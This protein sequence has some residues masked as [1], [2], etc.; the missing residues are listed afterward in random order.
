MVEKMLAYFGVCQPKV[1]VEVPS[2]Q[3]DAS[4]DDDTYSD[5]EPIDSHID[6]TRATERSDKPRPEQQHREPR[7]TRP[8]KHKCTHC[9]I[10]DTEHSDCQQ[11]DNVFCNECQTIEG[12]PVQSSCHFCGVNLCIGCDE[13]YQ[14]AVLSSSWK[15]RERV[16][17]FC[18][19]RC[20]K[21]S[22]RKCQRSF[23][24]INK[25]VYRNGQMSKLQL[26]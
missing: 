12:V 3:E 23:N 14:A 5:D 26:Q 9:G 1:T 22:L 18:S 15:G 2:D 7:W 4:F 21:D 19:Q 24:V 16:V 11:C 8:S 20:A 13:I 25:R 10:I 17:E 6:M